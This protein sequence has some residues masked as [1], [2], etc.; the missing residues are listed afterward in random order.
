MK[1]KDVERGF[2]FGKVGTNMFPRLH[3]PQGQN[4]IDSAARKDGSPQQSSQQSN[5]FS[6]SIQSS[7]S[8]TAPG[9]G[10]TK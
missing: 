3:N 7:Q 2:N 9:A 5:Q 10:F 1:T 6:T 4:N 8:V